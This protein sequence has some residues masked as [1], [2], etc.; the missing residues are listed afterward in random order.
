VPDQFGGQGLGGLFVERGVAD[1]EAVVQD[2]VGHVDQHVEVRVGCE[3]S[4]G[5][6]AFQQGAQGRA[7]DGGEVGQQAGDVLVVLGFGD[8]LAEPVGVAGVLEA[9]EAVGEE[10]RRPGRRSPAP[11][12]SPPPTGRW[13]RS[14]ARSRW[15]SRRC[16]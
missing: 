7:A 3:V 16:G 9:R 4:A 8:D 12:R 15:N 1:Q 14:S 2:A 6:A 11:P 10:R 13:N 5:L